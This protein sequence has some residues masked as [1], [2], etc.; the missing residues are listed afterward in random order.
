MPIKAGGMRP[1]YSIMAYLSKIT[2][3]QKEQSQ[4]LEK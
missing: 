1:A 4:N 3:K 2:N